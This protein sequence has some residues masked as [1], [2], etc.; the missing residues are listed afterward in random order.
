VR[1]RLGLLHQRRL[2]G[3]ALCC[4][5]TS[6]RLVVCRTNCLDVQQGLR[7]ECVDFS[8]ESRLARGIVGGEP[9]YL[10]VADFEEEWCRLEL[11]KS[12]IRLV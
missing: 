11:Q 1:E 3:P 6:V 7:V 5:Y 8:W 12:S 9:L 2:A 10:S 4:C